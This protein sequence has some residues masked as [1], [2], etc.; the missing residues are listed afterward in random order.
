MSAQE[1]VL[2]PK[3][4][5]IKKQPKASEILDEPTTVEKAKLLTILQRQPTKIRKIV[6]NKEE[7]REDD[8]KTRVL[9]SLTMLQPSKQEK[10]KSILGKIEASDQV[11][12][13]GDGMLK[14]NDRTTSIDANTFLFDLQ[15]S[16]T[17]IL[18][19]NPDYKRILENLDISPQM[20]G[21][22]QAKQVVKPT[23]TKKIVK[24]KSP[25]PKPTKQKTE[26]D[27]QSSKNSET[28]EETE[29]DW[30]YLHE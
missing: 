5:Y 25:K 12:I 7:K 20:V 22:S 11:S 6:D 17:K 14:L 10:S 23:R 9:K 27:Q 18:D 24:P 16:R 15:Q 4:N 3:E 8:M 1:F 28:E 26:N 2:I 13:D 19:K 30:E 29:K 21:N